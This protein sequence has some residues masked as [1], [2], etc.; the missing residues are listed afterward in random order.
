MPTAY[1]ARGSGVGLAIEAA[2]R[3]F[4]DRARFAV[5]GLGSGTLACYA[6]PGQSWTFY[7]IDPAIVR[8]ATDLR[9]SASSTAA[10]PILPS[11]SAMPG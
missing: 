2:P 5:V 7:E 4:G 3:L 1:Y 8:I 6:R 9:S 11:S 10:C